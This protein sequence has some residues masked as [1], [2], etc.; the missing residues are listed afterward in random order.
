[1]KN[2]YELKQTTILS[3]ENE[4]LRETIKELK[5]KIKKLEDEIKQAEGLVQSKGDNSVIQK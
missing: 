5:L 4:A 1:M 3:L 2:N